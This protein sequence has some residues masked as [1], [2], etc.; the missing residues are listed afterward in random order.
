MYKSN[1]FE[2]MEVGV[3]IYGL[4]IQERHKFYSNDA[5][6]A[7]DAFGDD[8]EHDEDDKHANTSYQQMMVQLG[9]LVRTV[10]NSQ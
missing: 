5:E 7:F 4:D 1:T 8:I 2:F 9:E 6:C 3:V 10:Q